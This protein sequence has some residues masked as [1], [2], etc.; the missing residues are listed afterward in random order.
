MAEEVI[1]QAQA[2]SCEATV[3]F[4]LSQKNWYSE[5]WDDL[6]EEYKEAW[7]ELQEDPRED[8]YL[9]EVR[10]SL[11][12]FRERVKSDTH[13]MSKALETWIDYQLTGKCW[14]C[15][16]RVDGTS[17]EQVDS[18]PCCAIC[19]RNLPEVTQDVVNDIRTE[20]R[21]RV[22]E[23]VDARRNKEPVSKKFKDGGHSHV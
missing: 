3:E 2:T 19:L 6:L 23:R 18:P 13:M 21:A 15:K 5:D 20:K 22:A 9:S 17:D 11:S 10:R 14:T 7:T 1:Y 16:C 8:R 4:Y 12:R